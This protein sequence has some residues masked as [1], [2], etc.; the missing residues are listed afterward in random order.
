M[1]C[2]SEVAFAVACC[3]S[4]DG[5][6]VVDVG[7]VGVAGVLVGACDLGCHEDGEYGGGE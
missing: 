3:D 1:C 6:A 2:C 4:G 7:V 5:V